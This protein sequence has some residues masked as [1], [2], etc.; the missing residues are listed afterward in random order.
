MKKNMYAVS[1]A[2][3]MFLLTISSC[4]GSGLQDMMDTPLIVPTTSMTTENE[5]IPETT[6]PILTEAEVSD[7]PVDQTAEPE[8]QE[9]FN[10][11]FKQGTWFSY[12]KD[13]CRYYFFNDDQ[14]NNTRLSVKSATGSAF[15][16]EISDGADDAHKTAVFHINTT[17]NN[18]K[19]EIIIND[20]ENISIIWEDKTEEKLTYISS[21]GMQQFMFYTDEELSSMGL[22]YYMRNMGKKD[23]NNTA[24]A[25]TN[26]DGSVTVRVYK[27]SNDGQQLVLAWYIVDRLTAAGEQSDDGLIKNGNA[28]D[29]K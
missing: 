6:E 18:T 19:A 7:E 28:V 5:K 24:D 14:N 8:Q 1:A 23:K 13:E 10:G 21:D 15:L 29:L 12:N 17:N 11:R 16:Y 22:N 25:R 27:N 2:L 3:L 20:P 26:E 9:S 4:S